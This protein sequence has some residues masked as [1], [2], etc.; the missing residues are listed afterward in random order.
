MLSLGYDN[1]LENATQWDRRF[2]ERKNTF[3]A[4]YIMKL[5]TE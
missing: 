2:I 5:G 3:L 4:C 1:G